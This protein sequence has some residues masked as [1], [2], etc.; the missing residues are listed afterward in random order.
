MEV[1]D[2]NHNRFRTEASVVLY[3]PIHVYNHRI[4]GIDGNQKKECLY[5]YRKMGNA[6][7]VG[8]ITVTIRQE[9]LP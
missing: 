5:S 8:I 3:D 2:F 7:L 1:P 6:F 9:D 4:R